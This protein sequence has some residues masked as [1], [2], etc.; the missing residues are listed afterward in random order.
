MGNYAYFAKDLGWWE[1]STQALWGCHYVYP[2]LTQFQV[3]LVAQSEL[4]ALSHAVA[5][6]DAEKF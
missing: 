6:G 3:A 1:E 2:S 5:W 4:L